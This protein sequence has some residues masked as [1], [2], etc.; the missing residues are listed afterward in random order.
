MILIYMYK[1]QS[2]R[3]Y[4]YYYAFLHIY[5]SLPPAIIQV[6]VQYDTILR[7]QLFSDARMSFYKFTPSLH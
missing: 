1:I 7:K 2:H 5:Y 3:L 4:D 6:Y